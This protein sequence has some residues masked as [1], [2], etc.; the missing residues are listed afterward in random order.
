MR[1]MTPA[2]YEGPRPGAKTLKQRRDSACMPQRL[3]EGPGIM[4][5]GQLGDGIERLRPGRHGLGSWEASLSW[6]DC[7][8]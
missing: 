8:R 5:A 3:L 6:R 4:L 1:D 2:S 7:G